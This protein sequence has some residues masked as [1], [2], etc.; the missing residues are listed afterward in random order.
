[1]SSTDEVLT[2]R[3]TRR[4][5]EITLTFALF[6]T[7]VAA[8]LPVVRVASPG[9]WLLGS[10]VLAALVLGAG[11]AARRYHLP[12]IAVSLIEG[13]VW[14]AFMTLVFLN[15]TALLWIIP[16][17]ETVREV[18][19]IFGQAVEEI[20][21]GAAPLDGSAALSFLIVGAMGLLTIIVD[22][23]VLSARMPLLAAIGIV[24]VSLIPAIAVPGDVDVSSFVF[25]AVAILGLLRA[26]TRSREKLPEREA[27]RNV[28]V[29]AT[30]LG[31]GAV[32]IVVAVVMTPLLPPPTFRGGNS[33]GPGSGVGID[34][35]LQL[36]DD[37]RRPQEVEVMRVRTSSAT[38]PY[39]RAT[40]LSRF[41]GDVWEPD[42][43][44]SVPLENELAFGTV[45]VDP[46]I[47]VT[48]YTTVIE[49]ANLSTGWLPVPYPAVDVQ[50]LDGSWD[51][52]PYNRTVI[53]QAGSTQGQSYTVTTDVPRPTLEQIRSLEANV[54]EARDETSGLP[55]DL[56][57]II[58]ELAA[59]VTADATNDYDRLIA[60]QRWFRAGDFEYSLESP[61]DNGFDGS[62][63]EAVAKFL[64][65]RE[66]YCVHFASA[67]A[68]MARTL[69]MPTRVVVGYLPGVPTGDVVESQPVY[70]V[71]SRQL[72]AWPEAYFDG[73]GWIAFEPTVSLGVPTS[74]S[75]ASSLPGGSSTPLEATPGATP[76]PSST[77]LINPQDQGGHNDAAS[78]STRESFNPLP[79][80]GAVLAILVL[81]AIPMLAR[82][83]RNRQYATSARRGDAASAWRMVQDAAIDVSI[84]VPPSES[85]RTFASRLVRNH[86]APSD[87]MDVLV[88]A[89]ERASYAPNGGRHFGSAETVTDA[90]AAV[91]AGLLRNAPPSRRALAI[92]APRSLIIRPGS[93]YGGTLSAN[94]TARVG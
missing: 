86:G 15:E 47:Q 65:V 23:V 82:E 5:G 43:K 55:A 41:E 26:E 2:S 44:R 94:A 58:A 87:P 39:L 50:G 75:P 11:F 54:T 51:A 91:R 89:I 40:T 88:S 79:A 81:L 38:P 36:G 21:L 60:L 6:A 27:E 70:S 16:T 8:L 67:F 85:P 45:T 49:V 84:A 74:F 25:L 77:A 30:A 10:V 18:P 13:A 35:T 14:V 59:A 42:R 83:L 9:L 71:S 68:L 34:A 61:V 12:A 80:L 53:A 3:P 62:G 46:D 17:P 20:M 33:F 7:L 93:V 19:V 78:G 57:P 92:L 64:E 76:Q 72:H 52:V 24:A 63:A 28:G 1:V 4:G 56:P 31:I 37:L 66:G 48:Q 73:V 90:A 22:H 69:L 29:P 32:A